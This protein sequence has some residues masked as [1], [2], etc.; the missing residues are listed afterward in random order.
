MPRSR[1]QGS[2]LT[3][4]KQSR[5]TCDGVIAI[6]VMTS[7]I[8]LSNIN[9]ERIMSVAGPWGKAA[10]APATYPHH[11]IAVQMYAEYIGWTVE[12]L[13]LNEEDLLVD[14]KLAILKISPE[15]EVIKDVGIRVSPT[16]FFIMREPK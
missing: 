15:G 16:E 11:V 6:V 4:E 2:A 10:N 8:A 9:K 7:S 5:K 12:H 3:A 13:Y 14:E 1:G